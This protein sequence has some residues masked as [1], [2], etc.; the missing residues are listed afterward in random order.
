MP[1]NPQKKI[2]EL[3]IILGLDIVLTNSTLQKGKILYLC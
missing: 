1:T 3:T 2:F